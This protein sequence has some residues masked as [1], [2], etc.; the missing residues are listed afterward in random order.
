M[1]DI[2]YQRNIIEIIRKIHNPRS[3]RLI[4]DYV[5]YL[6]LKYEAD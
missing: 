1:K 5:E 4:Y 6:F 3:L 2:E